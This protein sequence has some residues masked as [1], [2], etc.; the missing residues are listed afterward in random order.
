MKLKRIVWT[1]IIVMLITASLGV[2]FTRNRAPKAV[3]DSKWLMGTLVE[4]RVFGPRSALDGAFKRIEEIDKAMS[5]TAEDSHVYNINQKAGQS[6]VSVD[7]DT[8][9]VIQTA[10]EYAR[11]TDGLYDPSI[12]PLVEIWGI[13]TEQAKIPQPEAIQKAQ[14]LIDYQAI[15]VDT[16]G[17]RVKLERSEMA[18]DLGGIAKGYGA[19][20]ATEFLRSKGVQSAFLNLGGNVYVV[21]G[22]PDGSPWR[23]GIQDPEGARG[24][25]IAILEVKDTSIVT[26]GPYERYFLEDGTRY[27]HI[28]DPTTGFPAE[29]GLVSVTIVSPSSLTADALSTGVFV[30]GRE[31]GLALLESLDN[32]EGIL[33]TCDHQI[34]ATSGLKGRLLSVA[35]GFDLHE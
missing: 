8:L 29:S 19:D 32:V 7:K 20:A 14:S 9:H 2:A 12:G 25:H 1:I 13:G 22:K 23:I 24:T 4:M 5:R 35:K 21:G 6:W 30:L 34:Y 16:K 15:K 33:I 10:I 27:H 17:R 28:L 31:K 3:S 26:S 11:L 18:L